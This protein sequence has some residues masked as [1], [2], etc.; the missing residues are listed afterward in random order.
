MEAPKTVDSVTLPGVP[1]PDGVVK[2]SGSGAKGRT[3]KG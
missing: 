3:V 2:T 1:K